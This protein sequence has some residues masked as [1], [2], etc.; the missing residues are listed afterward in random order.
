ML[1]SGDPKVRARVKPLLEPMTGK[2]LELGDDP[3]RAASFKLFGNMMLLVITGGLADMFALARSLGIEPHGRV[4]V[5]H[6]VQPGQRV[7][8]RQEDGRGRF[9]PRELRAY[10]GA[11]GFAVDGRGGGAP[12]QQLDVVRASRRCWTA[13]SRPASAATTPAWSA[14]DAR[15]PAL[16]DRRRRRRDVERCATRSASSKTPR[17][18]SPKAARRTARASARTR[19]RR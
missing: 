5:V 18:R 12:R 17:A 11:Q 15:E 13:T 8:P 16:S 6:R 10:D 4:R 2:V 3:T 14:R 9:T 19:H 1:L 7:G